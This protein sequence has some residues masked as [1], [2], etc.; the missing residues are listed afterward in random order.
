MSRAQ[1]IRSCGNK[2]MKKGQRFLLL[3]A[4]V[5]R[6]QGR[7]KS[8]RSKIPNRNFTVKGGASENVV[9][10][11]NEAHLINL[12]LL[13]FLNINSKTYFLISGMTCLLYTSP[14]PRDGLLS[15]MPSSA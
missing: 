3:M 1:D 8:S 11:R 10:T 13:Q 9:N 5:W 14:S 2:L 4:E 7:I 15:R 6:R 12:G